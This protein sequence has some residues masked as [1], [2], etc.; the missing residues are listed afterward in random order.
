VGHAGG[1][2]RLHA[3]AGEAVNSALPAVGG[4]CWRRENAGAGIPSPPERGR[5][6]G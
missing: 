4:G 2:L 3:D 1:A 6:P 5:G